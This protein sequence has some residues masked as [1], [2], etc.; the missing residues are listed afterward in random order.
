MVKRVYLHIGTHKTGSTAI[1]NSLSGFDDGTTFYSRLNYANHGIPLSAAFM[2]SGGDLDVLERKGLSLN[3][4]QR[5]G[6]KNLNLLAKDLSRNDRDNLILSG[7][8][9][10]VF[11][12]TGKEKLINFI[13]QYTQDIVVICYAR[14]PQ[15][16][17][18]SKFQQLVKGGYSQIDTVLPLKYKTRLDKYKELVG[19]EKILIKEFAR[20]KLHKGC[21]VKDFCQSIGIKEVESIDSNDS[22]S[23]PALKLL[24]RFNQSNY[25]LKG[26]MIVSSAR[27][28]LIKDLKDLY[29]HGPAIN[30]ATFSALTDYSD[31]EYLQKEYGLN[32]EIKEAHTSL[33]ELSR[34]IMDLNDID[35]GLLDKKLA[36]LEIKG[37]F[38]RI[39]AKLNRLFYHHLFNASLH[40]N[41]SA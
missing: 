39:E 19:K 40:M 31:V 41:M 10:S 22:I 30:S 11:D 29:Q 9:L 16:F 23:M 18:A 12:D 4:I 14:N 8:G 15:S 37:N 2:K 1:Q 3:D 35:I 13:R 17:A 34:Q 24:F 28:A 26:D 38:N 32:F 7:E 33:Q 36:S 27:Q 25:C 20:E 6:Q 21:V 5:V